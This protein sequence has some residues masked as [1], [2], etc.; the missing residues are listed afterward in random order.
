MAK[1]ATQRATDEE[2]A[3]LGLP[4]AKEA[5][6]QSQ[7]VSDD[8]AAAVGLPPAAKAARRGPDYLDHVVA[9]QEQM[10]PR[11][12]GAIAAG[13]HGAAAG[14]EG[15]IN[16]AIAGAGEDLKN[17]FTTGSSDPAKAKA[18]YEKTKRDIEASQAEN[19]KEHPV[20]PIIGAVLAGGAGSAPT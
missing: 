2:A 14:L 13:A 11:M 16:G 20:A 10:L 8:E 9:E 18:V 12:W 19:L 5:L 15:P 6:A 17:I 7:R 4:P 1:P 3:A